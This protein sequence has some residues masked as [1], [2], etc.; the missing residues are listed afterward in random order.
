[1]ESQHHDA[2]DARSRILFDYSNVVTMVAGK[3]H[4]KHYFT[5][6]LSRLCQES[7]YFD[8]RLHGDYREACQRH[9]NFGSI[10]P[11]TVACM[12]YW[13]RGWDCPSC[14]ADAHHII[15]AYA[16]GHR[17]VVPRFMRHLVQKMQKFLDDQGPD[18][19]D[20]DL[21]CIIHLCR[22][23]GDECDLLD[24]I[25][26]HIVTGNGSPLSIRTL[27]NHASV[28]HLNDL[29]ELE[30]A[31]V[32]ELRAQLGLGNAQ[33]TRPSLDLHTQRPSE[34]CMQHFPGQNTPTEVGIGA[35]DEDL[36]TREDNLDLDYDLSILG[37]DN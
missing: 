19:A 2:A 9:I 18:I 32:S 5:F 24:C 15:D 20:V 31:K 35:Q 30:G 29:G 1:M 37:F 17:Y 14:E 23:V 16:L 13:F 36:S 12:L 26:R 3:G 7:T 33:R 10:N 4:M 21:G 8:D 11:H 22:V 6:D 27:H 25:A 28:K 34:F